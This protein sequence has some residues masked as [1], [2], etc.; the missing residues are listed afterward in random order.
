MMKSSLIERRYTPKGKVTSAGNQFLTGVRQAWQLGLTLGIRN[1]KSRYRQSML[2]MLWAFLPPIST[3]IVWI[4]LTGMGVINIQETEVPYPLFVIYGTTIWQLF[5][6]GINM[7][8]TS[9]NGNRSILVKINFPRTAVLVAGLVE[10]LV[11]FIA[12]LIILSLA[13]AW[14]GILPDI[15][16]LAGLIMLLLFIMLGVAIGLFLLPV[17]LLYKDVQY[18]LPPLLQLCMYLTP[19]IYP[20]VNFSG[21]SQLLAYNP[22]A[23]LVTSVRAWILNMDCVYGFEWLFYYLIAVLALLWVGYRVFNKSL[24]VLI[25]RMGS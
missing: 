1:V 19:V 7:P 17:A 10:M 12:A 6:Q 3:A 22:L 18:G 9:V 13:T 2:G 8:L 21:I 23:P 25:E 15:A 5:I 24:E 11:P 14:Y 20:Q 16:A 4:M